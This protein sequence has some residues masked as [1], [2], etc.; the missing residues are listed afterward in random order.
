MDVDGALVLA[1]SGCAQ[2]PHEQKWAMDYIGPKIMQPLQF[3]IWLRAAASWSRPRTFSARWWCC[4][5][6]TPTARTSA[7]PRWRTSPG[8]ASCWGL[9]QGCAGDLRHVD[10]KR[11]TPKVLDAYVHAFMSSAIG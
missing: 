4:I 7:R 5:S 11:D 8:R 1:F 3:T 10:P 2:Q 9:G 6:A